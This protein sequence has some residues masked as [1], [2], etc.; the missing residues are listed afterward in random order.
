[1]ETRN[2]RQ[3]CPDCRCVFDKHYSCL[4][5]FDIQRLAGK[6]SDFIIL[7]YPWPLFIANDSLTAEKIQFEDHCKVK[8]TW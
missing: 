2:K 8:V 5:T 7:G 1:M 6:K 4:C 3:E